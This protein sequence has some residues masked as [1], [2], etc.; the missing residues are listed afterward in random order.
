MTVEELKDWMDDRFIS[1]QENQMRL[2]QRLEKMNCRVTTHDH[3][4]WLMRGMGVVILLVLG[5]FGFKR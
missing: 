3:W 1:L 5:F 2:E 4:L